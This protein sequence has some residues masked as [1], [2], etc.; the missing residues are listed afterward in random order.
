MSNL[1]RFSAVRF[2]FFTFLIVFAFFAYGCSDGG[3]APSKSAESGA[4]KSAVKVEPPASTGDPARDNFNH[5]VQLALAG[6][7]NDAIEAYKKSIKHNP[8]SAAAHSNLG[9][10]YFDIKDFDKAAEFQE[11]ALDINPDFANAY[12]GLAMALEKKGDIEGALENWRE[13]LR[14]GKPHSIWWNNAKGGIK[15]HTKQ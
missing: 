1:K 5:G 13:Y 3:E 8:E 7:F 10:A 11:A 15:R 12:Y 6:N 4:G 2:A 14:L 9:F